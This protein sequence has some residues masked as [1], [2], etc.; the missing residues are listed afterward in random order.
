MVIPVLLTFEQALAHL[1][2]SASSVGSPGS[3][4]LED[5]DIQQKIN[6][7]TAMVVR[8][9]DR[10][11][12]A[13]WTATIEG[14]Y[15]TGSGSPAGSP[16][17]LAPDDVVAAVKLQFGELMRYRGDDASDQPARDVG[18]LSSTVRAL[19]CSYR[20]PVMA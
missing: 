6:A 4:N 16:V 5:Q 18:Q 8:Y 14:W 7:A 1:R 10:P 13:V 12:D 15:V 3:P 9:I 20:D 19:L 11:S 17:E 2:M